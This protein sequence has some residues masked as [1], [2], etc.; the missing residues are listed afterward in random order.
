M[1]TMS[2]EEFE[3]KYNSMQ[4]KDMAKEFNVCIDTIQRIRKKLNIPI[5]GKGSHQKVKIV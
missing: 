3:K 2:K 1:I 4:L 5:K